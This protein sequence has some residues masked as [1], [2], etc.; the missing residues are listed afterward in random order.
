MGVWCLYA[1]VAAI[2]MVVPV[3]DAATGELNNEDAC[4]SYLRWDANDSLFGVVL[5]QGAFK[6]A[7]FRRVCIWSSKW[8]HSLMARQQIVRGR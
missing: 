7:S 6:R 8:V 2:A 3:Y 1:Y 5:H 4:V